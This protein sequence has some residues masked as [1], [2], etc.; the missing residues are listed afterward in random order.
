[1]RSQLNKSLI[2]CDGLSTQSP[3]YRADTADQTL[4]AFPD[5][6]IIHGMFLRLSITFRHSTLASRV[7]RRSPA[8]QCVNIASKQELACASIVW[9][10]VSCPSH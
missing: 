10:G 9:P 3:P 2:I 5:I 4:S 7:I 6:P 8:W 1:M